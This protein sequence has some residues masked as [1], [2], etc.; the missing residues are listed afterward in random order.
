LSRS[1]NYRCA[2]VAADLRRARCVCKASHRIHFHVSE[3]TPA[4]A[5]PACGSARDTTA[6]S[7]VCRPSVRRAQRVTNTALRAARYPPL[8]SRANC[9]ERHAAKPCGL[10]PRSAA[11]AGR[12]SSTRSLGGGAY[13]RDDFQREICKRLAAVVIVPPTQLVQLSAQVRDRAASHHRHPCQ[14][15]L[16]LDPPYC[17]AAWSGRLGGTRA[18]P[19]GSGGDDLLSA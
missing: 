7:V 14:R 4:A 11:G 6:T 12:A 16:N 3:G 17:P 13:D 18:V 9:N 19:S 5:A 10:A 8:P 2:P 15:R 1:R